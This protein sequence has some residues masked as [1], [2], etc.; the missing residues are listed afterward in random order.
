MLRTHALPFLS[1]LCLTALPA[2]FTSHTSGAKRTPPTATLPADAWP[3][4][5]L[6]ELQS[7]RDRTPKYPDSYE[8]ADG[9]VLEWLPPSVLQR[10]DERPYTVTYNSIHTGG[11]L[12]VWTTPPRESPVEYDDLLSLLGDF[13][14]NASF[15]SPR[16]LERIQTL[17]QF[18]N[19]I[20]SPDLSYMFD[21][22][23]V[24]TRPVLWPGTTAESVLLTQG[25]DIEFPPIYSEKP[26]GLVLHILSLIS[27]KFEDDAVNAL[28]Q[29]G[30]AVITIDSETAVNTPHAPGDLEQF[31]I[32]ARK[33]RALSAQERSLESPHLFGSAPTDPKTRQAIRQT[34]DEIYPLL[35]EMSRLRKGRFTCDTPADA[36]QLGIELARAI[37]ANLA[38]HANAVT[39]VLDYVRTHR[40]DI[41]PRPLVIVGFSAGALATPAIAARL[42]ADNNAPDAIVLIGGGAD[43]LEVSRN[44]GMKGTA[45]PIK[46]NTTPKDGELPDSLW[47]PL[48]NSYIRH[49]NLDPL[50]TAP[51]LTNIPILQIHATYDAIVPA[52]TGRL[53]HNLLGQPDRIDY[54]LGHEPMFYH[55]G[56]VQDWIADWLDVHTKPN[57][58][59]SNA[60]AAVPAQAPAPSTLP[61][62]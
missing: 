21:P 39:A 32:L 13:T 29:R 1:L 24:S 10:F 58:T 62:S 46:S 8:L 12:R 30:W 60:P 51:L 14:P 19:E 5:D 17:A 36:E 43:L 49:T 55:L 2:C 56:R 52:S 61:P 22:V 31:N 6:S 27:N 26:R 45:I 53:L 38:D 25:L 4:S 18:N 20:A 48:H 34:Q 44:T 37:D 28:R 11:L 33:Y 35:R 40:P 57:P 54:F 15:L 3:T 50:K 23:A 7:L 41:T 59:P 9:A 16:K 42:I 47:T